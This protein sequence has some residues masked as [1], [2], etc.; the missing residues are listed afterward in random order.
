M[1]GGRRRHEQAESRGDAASVCCDDPAHALRAHVTRHCRCRWCMVQAD[2]SACQRCRRWNHRQDRHGTSRPHQD[3]LPGVIYFQHVAVDTWYD[4]Q[5]V[6]LQ[7]STTRTPSFS[8]V[9]SPAVHMQT[10]LSRPPPQYST[11]TKSPPPPSPSTASAGTPEHRR[12]HILQYPLPEGS[13]TI[14]QRRGNGLH[15]AIVG[16]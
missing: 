6:A 9:V 5:P 12:A 8:A 13:Q 2:A 3:P 16:S 14:R 11:C 7:V 15:T 1:A 10:L 4:A